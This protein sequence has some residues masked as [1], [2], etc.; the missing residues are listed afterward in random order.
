MDEG[1]RKG[2]K[3]YFTRKNIKGLIFFITVATII[4]VVI[5]VVN[6]NVNSEY[7]YKVKKGG[8]ILLYNVEQKGENIEV[9]VLLENKSSKT[10][11]EEVPTP[12]SNFISVWIQDKEGKHRLDSKTIY[13]ESS[14]SSIMVI[15]EKT[16]EPGQEDIEIELI[17]PE[18]TESKYVNSELHTKEGVAEGDYELHIQTPFIKEVLKGE[19]VD[20]EYIVKKGWFN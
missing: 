9:K 5:S 15:A 13:P 2:L 3:F 11:K 17:K 12:S 4:V 7:P 19:F 20:G 1:N 10:F 14:G 8:V 18:Y 6:K 16:F